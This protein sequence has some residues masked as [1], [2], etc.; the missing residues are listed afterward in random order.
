[1]KPA[2]LPAPLTDADAPKGH[3]EELA[4]TVTE[5]APLVHNTGSPTA[6]VTPAAERKTLTVPP[7][8][9]VMPKPLHNA[10]KPA[11]ATVPAPA[12]T[13]AREEPLAQVSAMPVVDER[14]RSEQLIVEPRSV[15]TIIRLQEQGHTTEY[16]R[17]S[18]AYGAVY[19]FRNGES[20]TEREFEGVRG[21]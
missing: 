20:V 21:N 4:P 18:H 1:L 7:R 9:A 2:A 15:T 3:F 10:V 16:R 8:P 5:V 6:A 13:A 11:E 12:V 19:F 14:D 17:V